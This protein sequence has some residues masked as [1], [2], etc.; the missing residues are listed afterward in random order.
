MR[1][2]RLRHA[3]ALA[4]AGWLLLIPNPGGLPFGGERAP[5][6]RWQQI[7]RPFESAQQCE[8]GRIRLAE[9]TR[10]QTQQMIDDKR[11]Y[12]SERDIDNMN[13][14]IGRVDLARCISDDDPD[15]D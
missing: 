14:L 10:T 1:R 5:L 15:L 3:A 12:Y 9:N 8:Q 11:S 4:L 2:K 13:D 7:G 6:H